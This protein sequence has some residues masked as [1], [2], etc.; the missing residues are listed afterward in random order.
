MAGLMSFGGPSGVECASDDSGVVC[1]MKR[2]AAFVQ[3]IVYLGVMAGLLLWVF[4][5]RKRIWK[6]IRG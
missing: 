6:T 3:A 5:H 4:F 1:T 2:L